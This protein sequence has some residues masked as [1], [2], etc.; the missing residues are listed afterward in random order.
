MVINLQTH[1][2]KNNLSWGT[3]ILKISQDVET[4]W[5]E[6]TW[7]LFRT[8]FLKKNSLVDF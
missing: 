4:Q 2:F 8:I 7:I 6:E 3:E 1:S 5:N